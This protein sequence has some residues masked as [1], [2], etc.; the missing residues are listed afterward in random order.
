MDARLIIVQKSKKALDL[1][2]KIKFIFLPP[3][4]S[5]LSQMLDAT[6]FST[7]KRKYANIEKDLSMNSRFTQKLVKIKKAYQSVVNEELIRS[8]WR[9]TGFMLKVHND[10]VIGYEFLED[11]KEVLRA[12]ASHSE[13]NQVFI[14]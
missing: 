4:S 2:G 6:L 11:F 9:A 10:E 1:I 13:N 5:H 12:A 14:Q 3:H 8:S 7:L